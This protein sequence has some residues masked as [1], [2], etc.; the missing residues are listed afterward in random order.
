MKGY[1]R[2]DHYRYWVIYFDCSI[3]RDCWRLLTTDNRPNGFK[4]CQEAREEIDRHKNASWG[5][6]R[7]VEEIG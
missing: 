6:Y 2:I 1:K 4:S 3:G 5:L 7:I